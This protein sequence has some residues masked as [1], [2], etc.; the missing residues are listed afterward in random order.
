[1]IFGQ[2]NLMVI[3]ILLDL[4]IIILSF[5]TAA[6]IA[7][8]FEVLSTRLYMLILPVVCSTLWYFSAN[9][10]GFYED[11]NSRYFP[12]QIIYIAK[13][14]FVQIFTAIVFIFLV[15]E[16]LYTRNFVISFTAILFTGIS[17][18]FLILRK[19]IK[20]QK[21]R[22]I[23]FRKL[24]IIGAGEVG[25]EFKEIVEK[26]LSL[27]F[28]FEGFLDDGHEYSGDTSV[29]GNLDRLEHILVTRKIDEVVVALPGR[30][31]EALE[32]IMRICNKH[33]VRTYIIPDYFKF[34]ARKFRVS[35]IG[36]FPI[37]T[38]RNE[39]LEEVHYQFVKRLFDIVFSLLVILL[40]ASWL[41]PI[42]IILQKI[43]SPGPVFYSQYRIGKQNSVFTCFKFRSM[44]PAPIDRVF[45]ATTT[46]DPRITKFGRFLRKTN[47]DELP[48]IFNVLLGDMSIV[49]PRPH[50]VSYN[51]KYAE[52]IEELRL[53]NLVKP[54]ITGWAQVHGLRGDV[55]N[56]E[57][58]KARILKRFEF[59]IWY[60][61]NWSFSLDIQIIFL[62]AWELI[63]GRAKGV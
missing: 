56:E 9:V 28:A 30:L 35:L 41:F 14:V 27:G 23:N 45:K 40:L 37:I 6:L 33:A 50:A 62:T 49:G 19:I 36:N 2:K 31:P 21:A 4:S 22:G 3:R 55:T 13:N 59:D 12:Y 15:K 25:R 60:V 63:R 51:E 32:N 61:E 20:S 24:L 57:E 46:D 17:L 16:D 42:I 8:S 39:P 7:Q 54:G 44:T 53:R 48:Q 29:L 5:V 58:N 1:M 18:E 52:F 34:L 11:F 43:L 10:T 26:D 47:I 38:V